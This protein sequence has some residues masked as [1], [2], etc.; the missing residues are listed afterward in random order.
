MNDTT[1]RQAGLSRAFAIRAAIFLSCM[2]LP[3]ILYSNSLRAPFIFD[4]FSFILDKPDVRQIGGYTDAFVKGRYLTYLTFSLNYR[5]GGFD[6]FG[7]HL[8]NIF[9]HAL[10]AGLVF[11]LAWKLTAMIRSDDGQSLFLSAGTALLFAVQPMNTESVAYIYHRS[12][13]L[14]TAFYLLSLILFLMTVER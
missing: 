3:F 14:S 2:A 12:E 7:F 8:F 9:A 11:I 6:T 13:S 5:M 1:V 4:D 10:A